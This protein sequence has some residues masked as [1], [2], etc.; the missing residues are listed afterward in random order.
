MLRPCHGS[1]VGRAGLGRHRRCRPEGTALQGAR[2]LRSGRHP[3]LG[4][5][6]LRLLQGRGR[7]HVDLILLW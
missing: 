5:S 7:D 1:E 4:R 6:M 3:Q 2:E